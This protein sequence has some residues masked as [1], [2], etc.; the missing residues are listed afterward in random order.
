MQSLGEIINTYQSLFYVMVDL[1][2]QSI[3]ICYSVLQRVA[4]NL[5]SLNECVGRRRG[6]VTGFFWCKQRIYRA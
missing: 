3:A 5:H 2:L 4:A 1:N 6:G